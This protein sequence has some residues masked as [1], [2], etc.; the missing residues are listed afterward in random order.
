MRLVDPEIRLVDLGMRL[1]E[2]GMRLVELG[3]RL[4]D[5]GMKLG[6]RLQWKFSFPSAQP[7]INRQSGTYPTHSRVTVVTLKHPDNDRIG[8]IARPILVHLHKIRYT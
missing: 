6:M 8:R 1:V 4:V 7:M 3:M 5:L 2:L